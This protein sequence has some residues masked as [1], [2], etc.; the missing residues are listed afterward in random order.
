VGSAGSARRWAACPSATL[1]A[2]LLI[3]CLAFLPGCN[4]GSSNSGESTTESTGSQQSG[5]VSGQV[6]EAI[7]AGQLRI[8]VNS[9]EETVNPAPPLMPASNQPVKPLGSNQ[10]FYQASLRVDN[11]GERPVLVEPAQFSC[12]LGGNVVAVDLARSG[13]VPRSLLRNASLDLLLTFEGP[14]GSEPELLYRP[15]GYDGVVHVKP[16]A[17]G[18]TTSSS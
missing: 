10:S 18:A 13:P 17:S 5:D 15:A 7:E 3:F 14:S 6:G 9:I 11:T 12:A 1:A 8:T 16:A 4:K 2:L